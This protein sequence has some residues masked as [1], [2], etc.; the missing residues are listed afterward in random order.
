MACTACRTPEKLA[1][2]ADA[3]VRAYERSAGSA[4]MLGQAGSLMNPAVIN[5]LRELLALIR[6]DFM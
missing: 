2:A 3:I 6:S 5:R 4:G 1:G